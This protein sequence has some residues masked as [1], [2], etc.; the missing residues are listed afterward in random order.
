MSLPG[1]EVPIHRS[2][3]EEILLAG[4]PR[5]ACII[6]GTLMAAFGLQLHSLAV[7]P[8]GLLFHL[9]AVAATRSDPQFFD[10]FKRHIKQKN[11]Y[12]V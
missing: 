7:L 1:Y 2:L 4:V 12:T 10:C 11:L 3:T 6:N 9:L 8:I 5:A